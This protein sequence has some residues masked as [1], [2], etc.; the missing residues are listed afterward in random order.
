MLYKDTTSVHTNSVTSR[1]HLPY[2]ALILL[3]LIHYFTPTTHI[4]FYFIRLVS[5]VYIFPTKCFIEIENKYFQ[6]K[7]NIWRNNQQR[8]ETYKPSLYIIF[9]DNPELELATGDGN[10]VKDEKTE[11]LFEEVIDFA[12]LSSKQFCKIDAFVNKSYLYELCIYI[13]SIKLCLLEKDYQIS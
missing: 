9:A 7:V 12:S 13:L 2:T 5:H 1:S 3:R 6:I 11:R 10:P 4:F 8:K